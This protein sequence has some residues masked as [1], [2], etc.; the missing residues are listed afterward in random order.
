MAVTSILKRTVAG[1]ATLLAAEMAWA[2]AQPVPAFDDLDA[3]GREGDPHAPPLRLAVLGDSSC[4]GPGLDDPADIWVRVLGRQIGAR[5]DVT[6]RSFAIGG[7]RAA[8]L[9]RAQLQ[10]AIQWAPDVAMV[11]VGGNDALKGVSLRAFERS[12]EVVV[13]GLGATVPLVILSGVG[14]LGSIPRLLPPLDRIYRARGLRL[15][16]VHRRVGERQGAI[17]ADQWAWAAQEFARRPEL[18]SADRF[19]PGPDGHRIWADVARE[20]IEPHLERFT[21]A[22]R[23]ERRSR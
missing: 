7:S 12:L 13:A 3:S 22:G 23:D 20:T 14:D 17:V 4:T 6:I 16:E 21:P 5:F 1:G 2:I 18:F 8:D 11:S 10:P 15:N 9:V 19:H